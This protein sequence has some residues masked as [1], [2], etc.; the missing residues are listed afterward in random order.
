MKIFV[1]GG[2]GFVGGHLI[3]ALAKKHVVRALA[4]SE[5]SAK[6][7]V[8]YGAFAAR[9]DLDSL[10]AADLEGC[11]A[12][13]HCA[14]RAEEWGTRAEFWSANV[15]G[16]R[17]VLAAAKNARVRRFVH[18]GTEAAFFDGRD[19]VDVDETVPY[20]KKHKYLYSE[21]KA[22]AERLVL[23]ANDPKGAHPFETISL[24][25]RFVWGPRDT[26]VLPAVLA[27]AKE[28]RFVWLDKGKARTSTTHVAN[29]V[30]AIELALTKGTPGEAY[31]IADDGTRSMRDFLT[32]LARTQGVDL[33]AKSM[34]GALARPVARVVEKAW[35]VRRATT[36][37]PLTRFAID[38]L[39]ATV[40]VDTRKAKRDLGYE[41]VIG[42]D[43]GL[44]QLAS[45]R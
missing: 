21:T 29:L 6:K 34:P 36:K 24:R 40:T 26:S 38:M 2:S 13:V 11:E 23:A 16:T 14:A 12:V 33:P 8:G 4:R 28:G 42:V 18:I 5:E 22:E 43:E 7:V 30:H 9:A 19:L 32:A 31:F 44:A 45:G 25:P 10:G 35:R 3:E 1:T 37:P 20:P 17:R 15:D 39:S 41:P 27:M